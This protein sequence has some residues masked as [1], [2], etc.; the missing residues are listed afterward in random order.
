MPHPL[1][2]H[3]K[4]LETVSYFTAQGSYFNCLFLKDTVV[5]LGSGS[6]KS[7]SGPV[8]NLITILLVY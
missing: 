6:K 5:V 7:R 1:Y 8:Q 3:A 2:V 4:V